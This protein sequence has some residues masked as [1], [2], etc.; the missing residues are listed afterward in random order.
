MKKILSTVL[1]L[2]MI[3]S[4]G[5]TAF[6]E[7]NEFVLT[8][9]NEASYEISIPESGNIDV[10]NGKGTITIGV[11]ETNLADGTVVSVTATSANYTDDS[12]YLV[13]T[14][15]SSDK[16][17]YTVGTT[18]GGSDVASGDEVLSADSATS[19]TLYVTLSDTSK[20]GTFTDTITFTSEIE[21]A[22]ATVTV[23]HD[24][25]DTEYWWTDCHATLPDSSY[26][27]LNSA[28]IYEL[29]IGT[30]ITCGGGHSYYNHKDASLSVYL[31]GEVVER[32]SGDGDGRYCSYEYTL[33][34]NI[35]L[36]PKTDDSRFSYDGSIY[37]AIHITEE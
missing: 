23:T 33:N 12:W 30:V 1:C 14:K 29:P 17:A 35:T 19:T 28:G 26:V 32:T 8:Y 22:M 18:D 7:T 24:A 13:N 10:T 25:Y 11:T 4:L 3:L 31:N 21:A 2:V 36:D 5:V 27:S 16:M 34:D 20:I 6:A 15:D 37:G 9:S